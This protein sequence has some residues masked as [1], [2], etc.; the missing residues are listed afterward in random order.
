MKE[1]KKK[2]ENKDW[3]VSDPDD[4]QTL[5]PVGIQ[6]LVSKFL[7]TPSYPPKKTK[8]LFSISGL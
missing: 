6:L 5:L 8:P 4:G 7:L 1:K 2:V 3:G